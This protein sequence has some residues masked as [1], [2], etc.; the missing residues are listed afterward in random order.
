MSQRA[1]SVGPENGDLKISSPRPPDAHARR[2]PMLANLP[3]PS[4]QALLAGATEYE[5][6]AGQT[7]FPATAEPRA[8]ILSQGVARTYLTSTDGRQVTV[9]YA[10]VGSLIGN[11]WG[12]STD[13]APV[14]VQAVSDCMVIELDVRTL[15]SVISSDGDVAMEFV[16]ELGR[17]IN[18]L[19]ATLAANA[20][21]TMRERIAGH[22]VDMAVRDETGLM[23]AAIT[24][25][26]LADSVGTVR[27]V[28]AR[29]LGDLRRDGLIGTE[30]GRVQIRDAAGLAAIV[31]RRRGGSRPR[32]ADAGVSTEGFLDA[33]PNAIMAIDLDGRIVYANGGAA[34]MF[35]WSRR[36]LQGIP[37]ERLIPER[38][39]A[40]HADYVA[41]FLANPTL[42]PM[43]SGLR[44]S[45]RRKDGSEFPVDISLAPVETPKGVLVFATVIEAPASGG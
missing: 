22:L 12:V 24:Q 13:R 28:V 19:Y 1:P 10:R 42:R 27:E 29:I 16:N 39:V 18:E 20:F 35:G 34:R 41:H 8:A 14:G 3:D 5:V 38:H 32:R 6:A 4:R 30:T 37:V 2:E 26:Q 15:L 44:L 43:G 25:Q 23:Y 9:C 17:R 11:V 31:A 21:S 7:I 40:R 33:S 45:A 36:E